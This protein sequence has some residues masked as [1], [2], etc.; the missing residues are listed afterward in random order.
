ISYLTLELGL[1]WLVLAAFL[2]VPAGAKAV[3]PLALLGQTAFLFYLLHVHLLHAAARALGLEHHA[4]LG[5]TYVAAA[6]TVLALFPVCTVYR[7]YKAAHP[8]GWA[9]YV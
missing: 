6:V 3:A 8:E 1:S 4:G 9:R 2:R 5:A 7:R